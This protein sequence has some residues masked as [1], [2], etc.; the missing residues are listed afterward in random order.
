MAPC[1]TPPSYR[2]VENEL[3]GQAGSAAHGP[4]RVR[5]RLQGADDPRG[6]STNGE[7][8]ASACG[9]LAT[10]TPP[11]VDGPEPQGHLH[12]QAVPRARTRSTGTARTTSRSIPRR[13]TCCSRTRSRRSREAD[14]VYVT[15]RLVG[16]DPDYALPVHTV[17]DKALSALF[18]DNMFRPWSDE[19]AAARPASA[20]AT[21]RS[22]RSR[23]TSSTPRDT[24]GGCASTRGSGTRRPWRGDGLRP[25]HRRRLR[26][27]VLR[28]HEEAHLHRDE[29]HAAGRGHPA[30]CT[31]ARTRAPTGESALLLGLSGT[32]KTTLSAD[33][34]RALLGDD[35][36]GWNDDGIA[37]F[38]YGCYAKLIDLDPEKEP[39]IYER[40]LPQ[41]RG[42]EPRL[43]HRERD[44][45]PVGRVRSLR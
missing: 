10:W 19:V 23:I 4:G 25:P 33:A 3:S 5:Q 45:V 37:N 22:S 16:A 2:R 38:E 12:R 6:A 36:H 17:G 26:L 39:E 20:T 27:G 24:R 9:A 30:R 31:A 29:L 41:G 7:A 14:R 21:S 8:V 18:T 43:H 35:E 11:G 44:D 40:V 1:H 34:S 42:R 28:E 32:G 15:D 13:S